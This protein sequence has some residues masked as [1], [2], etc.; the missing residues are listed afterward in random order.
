MANTQTRVF[1][2][3]AVQGVAF[4]DMDM[5]TATFDDINLKQARFNNI[6]LS[7]ATFTDINFSHA[8]IEESCIEGLIIWGVEVKPLIEA[9]R[10]RRAEAGHRV[11]QKFSE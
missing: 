5:Q 10:Q 6:N 11:V 1:E 2:N 3:Q 8:T 9:E 4:H 7:G